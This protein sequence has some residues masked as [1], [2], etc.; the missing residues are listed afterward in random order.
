MANDGRFNPPPQD[1]VQGAAT[2]DTQGFINPFEIRV[3][4][5]C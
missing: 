2:P 1:A 4:R 3:G 5:V